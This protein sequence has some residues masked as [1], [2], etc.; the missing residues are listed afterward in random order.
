[1]PLNC[2]LGAGPPSPP[3][4]ELRQLAAE[5]LRLQRK[6]WPKLVKAGLLPDVKD[7]VVAAMVED[8]KHRHRTGL[9]EPRRCGP[10]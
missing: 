7:D 8:F 1:M 5:Y 3:D 9:V 6:H 10:S 4:Q 2:A